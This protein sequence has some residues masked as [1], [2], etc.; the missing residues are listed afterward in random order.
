L[1][2]LSPKARNLSKKF[3]ED[4]HSHLICRVRSCFY[5]RPLLSK[6]TELQSCL[7]MRT[8]SQ[9]CVLRWCHHCE[10]IIEY[11][12]TTKIARMS[13]GEKSMTSPV[14]T[15]HHWQKQ[16]GIWLYRLANHLFLVRV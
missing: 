11:T 10:K 8:S 14:Y 1:F 7:V 15:V 16:C 4:L 5:H 2:F 12:Y 9:K 6:V 3:P 13:L